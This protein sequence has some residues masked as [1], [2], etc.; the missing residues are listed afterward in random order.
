VALDHNPIID[1]NDVIPTSRIS[2]WTPHMWRMGA[3]AKAGDTVERVHFMVIQSK[4][5]VWAGFPER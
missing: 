3:D 4:R 1:K 5:P 2:D